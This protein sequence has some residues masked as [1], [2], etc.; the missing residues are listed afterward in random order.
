MS[1]TCQSCGKEYKI[2]VSIPDDLWELIKPAGK[3]KGAGLLCG[4]CIF[5][6]LESYNAYL[7]FTIVL[8]KVTLNDDDG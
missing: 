8:A 6:R 7:A 2:D 4:S 1:C 5:D 3:P